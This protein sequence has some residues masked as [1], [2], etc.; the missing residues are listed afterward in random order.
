[1]RDR[2]P[3]VLAALALLV[4]L[5]G[6]ASVVGAA[7]PISARSLFAKDAGTVDHIRASRTPKAGQLLPLGSNAKFPASVIP[8]VT[9]GTGATGA[10]GP[11]GPAGAQGPAG[12]QG[13]KG[14]PGAARAYA[15][16]DNV[17]SKLVNA[18]DVTAVAQGQYGA[19]D[20]CVTLDKSID[21]S[22]AIAQ[23]AVEY[24]LGGTGLAEWSNESGGCA[25]HPNSVQI[26]TF[27]TTGIA[28][29]KSFT[30][31]VP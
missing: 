16:W 21:A 2:V 18:H 11:A 5:L 6:A 13:P 1:M 17:H 4:A 28:N 19:G 20:W 25:N 23:A 30:V 9:G 29:P 27:S 3:L 7:G 26:W 12:P 14:D 15:L 31:I 22:S 24:N 10:A 8:V